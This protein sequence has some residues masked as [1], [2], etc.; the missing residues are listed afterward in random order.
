MKLTVGT[1]KPQGSTIASLVAEIDVLAARLDKGSTILDELG[2]G[3]PQYAEALQRWRDL[4]TQFLALSEQFDLVMGGGDKWCI[5]CDPT[6]D[7]WH[8]PAHA[9]MCSKHSHAIRVTRGKWRLVNKDGAEQDF[10][11]PPVPA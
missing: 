3:H 4:N 6:L 10:P 7:A 11:A 2:E 9:R 8:L 5:F 1:P